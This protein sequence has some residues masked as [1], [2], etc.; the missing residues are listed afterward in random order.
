MFEDSIRLLLYYHM[1]E[2]ESSTYFIMAILNIS[3]DLRKYVLLPIFV[4]KTHADIRFHTRRVNQIPVLS[5]T[6]LVS[7]KSAG[8]SYHE[9]SSLVVQKSLPSTLGVLK[10]SGVR[11]HG[12]AHM[13]CLQYPVKFHNPLSRSSLLGALAS[14]EFLQNIMNPIFQDLCLWSILLS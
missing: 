8:I 6:K 4:T 11:H 14:W 2:D 10:S 1:L 7:S 5:V 12:N 3:H 13:I 9:R